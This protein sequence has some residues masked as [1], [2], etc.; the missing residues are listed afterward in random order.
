MD[1]RFPGHLAIIMRLG[2]GA[3]SEPAT[4]S[5]EEAVKHTWVRRSVLSCCRSIYFALYKLLQRL[6]SELREGLAIDE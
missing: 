3:L 6:C 4:H 2:G 1:K 5:L